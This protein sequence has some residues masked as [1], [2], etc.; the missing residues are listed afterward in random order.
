MT[1]AGLIGTIA[2]GL[3]MAGPAAGETSV[4]LGL[5]YLHWDEDTDPAVTETG[6]LFALGLGYTQ[7]RN[8]GL[9][10]AYRGRFYLG[11]VDYDG[12]GLFT[13]MP[14]QGTSRYT[15]MANEGQL[16]WRTRMKQTYRADLLLA[17]GLDVWERKLTSSQ[18]EDYQVGYLR[19]GG[20][21]DVN[22]GEGWT[23]GAGVK[24]PFYTHEDAHLTNIGFDSNPTLEPGPDVS[25]FAH[26]GYRFTDRVSLI[27]YYDGFRFKKSEEE[28]VSH[29]VNGNGV[30]FQPASDMTIIGLKLEYRMK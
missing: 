12:A 10:F 14:I 13:G 30:I 27:A 9:L 11:E 15:G 3:C 22:E 5:E 1:K 17:L 16:R 2:L 18:S 28:A 7:D 21:F 23:A 8:S 26:L 4:S 20:E 24:Y 29:P 19:L 25:L 6:P